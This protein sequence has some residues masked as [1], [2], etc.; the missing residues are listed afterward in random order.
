MFKTIVVAL[1]GSEDGD[2][3]LEMARGIASEQ[4]SRMVVVHVTEFVG[5]KGGVYPMAVDEQDIKA[6]IEAQ[7]EKLRA[8]GL[9]AEMVSRSVFPGGP[10]QVIAEAA[11]SV[12]ADLI[13]V[14]GR[15]RAPIGDLLVGSVPT[16]LLHIAHR[17]V[18]VVPR[19]ATRA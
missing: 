8:D 15:G 16:R 14:G 4:G 17:P 9:E 12:D 2:R 19:P 7:V 6:K 5:G 11:D 13:V 10:G 1:D 18:L 3:A